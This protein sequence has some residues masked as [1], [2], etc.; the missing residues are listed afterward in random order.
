[1]RDPEVRLMI[2]YITSIMKKTDTFVFEFMN[3]AI[4]RIME[5]EI[6]KVF[7]KNSEDHDK[8]FINSIIPEE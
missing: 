5:A 8:I 4:S 1:L 7:E 6:V 3:T 2:P